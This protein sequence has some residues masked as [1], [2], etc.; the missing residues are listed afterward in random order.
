MG[1]SWVA[2]AEVDGGGVGERKHTGRL[3]V[4]ARGL[5]WH[6]LEGKP[7]RNWWCRVQGQGYALTLP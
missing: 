4:Q 5:G 6:K 7:C 3:E 2:W 1:W